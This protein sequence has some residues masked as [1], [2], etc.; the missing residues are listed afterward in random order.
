[1]RFYCIDIGGQ[2]TRVVRD[3][4]TSSYIVTGSGRVKLILVS[5]GLMD[6]SKHN[7]LVLSD[8]GTLLWEEKAPMLKSFVPKV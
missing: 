3:I 2:A 8:F 1:M 7:V 5:Y 4:L 6:I